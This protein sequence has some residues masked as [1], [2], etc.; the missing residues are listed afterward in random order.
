MIRSFFQISF[1]AY[2]INYHYFY[3]LSS[4]HLLWGSLVG[5]SGGYICL[6][7]GL[8]G[9]VS[10]TSTPE[11]RTMRLSILNGVFSAAYAAGSAVGGVMYRLN[12]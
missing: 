8:Y 7:L 5:C 12:T 1:V 4:M 10:D 9:Y 3:Q 11:D 2:M 6:N